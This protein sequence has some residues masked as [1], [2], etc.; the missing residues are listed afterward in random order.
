M[1]RAIENV[2]ELNE[3]HANAGEPLGEPLEDTAKG[4][5]SIACISRAENDDAGCDAEE[6][7]MR[8][9]IRRRMDEEREALRNLQSAEMGEATE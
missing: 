8:I 7:A 3:E 1:T 9:E 6:L 4:A 5:P 2:D